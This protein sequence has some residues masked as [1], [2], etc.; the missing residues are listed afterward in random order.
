MHFDVWFPRLGD[1]LLFNSVSGLDTVEKLRMNPSSR[2]Q[3]PRIV[4]IRQKISGSGHCGIF[5]TI[6]GF[7]WVPS[8][9][10]MC[11]R[12]SVLAAN[13]LQFSDKLDVVFSPR[14]LRDSQLVSLFFHVG[15]KDS[16]IVQINQTRRP[17]QSFQPKHQ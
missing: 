11:L 8:A 4:G 2:R 9:D 10:T 1:I 14:L 15:P 5:D 7:R 17:L 13:K 12:N 3:G 6:V 16:N